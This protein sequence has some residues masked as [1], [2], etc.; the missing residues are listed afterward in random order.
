MTGLSAA[1][2]LFGLVLL[3]G[4][5]VVFVALLA[6]S[7][8]RWSGRKATRAHRPTEISDAWAESA[9][10]VPSDGKGVSPEDGDRS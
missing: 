7:L 8:R 5:A 1:L 4:L 2:G 3:A 10:R 6:I 9:R